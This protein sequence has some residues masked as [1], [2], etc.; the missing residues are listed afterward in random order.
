MVVWETTGGKS[1][2]SVSNGLN[3]SKSTKNIGSCVPCRAFG[4]RLL[5]ELA[6]LIS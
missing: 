3:P 6:F 2:I 1:E 4:D 5:L